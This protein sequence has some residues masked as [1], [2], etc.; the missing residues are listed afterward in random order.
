M[1]ETVRFER[2][3]TIE[4]ET[5]DGEFKGHLES[6]DISSDFEDEIDTEHFGTSRF[7]SVSTDYYQ[8]EHRKLKIDELEQI[9][10]VG[11]RKAEA[12]YREGYKNVND[13]RIAS[14]SELNDIDEIG[15]ALAARIKADVGGVG[16]DSEKVLNEFDGPV[17]EEN[18]EVNFLDGE[19]LMYG[20]E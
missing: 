10:G 18:E 19:T 5:E 15:N 14:Q 4:V 17:E 8:S 6:V 3:S 7:Q 16:V 9:S 13:V 1:T 20:M 12:L 11:R 2:G